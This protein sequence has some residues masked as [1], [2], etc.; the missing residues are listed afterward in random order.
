[1]D[2]DYSLSAKQNSKFNINFSNF[3]LFLLNV[4]FSDQF[5]KGYGDVILNIDNQTKKIVSGNI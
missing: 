4:D 3:G 5:L 2:F 1:M